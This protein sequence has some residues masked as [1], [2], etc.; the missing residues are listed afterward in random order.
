MALIFTPSAAGRPALGRRSASTRQ[1]PVEPDGYLPACASATH[2]L[3]KLVLAAPESFFS[4]A[5]ASHA[6][7]ASLSH[8]FMKL[9]LAAPASFFSTAIAAQLP[10]G[11]AAAIGALDAMAGASLC[12]AA[13]AE[14]ESASTTAA[15]SEIHC[16]M[17]FSGLGFEATP[18][19]GSRAG[20]DHTT[21]A[22][23]KAH[24]PQR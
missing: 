18:R 8:F 17:N 19:R 13:N 23:S 2:F 6:A 5:L 16:F 11:A 12:E 7:V 14:V 24:A 21:F 9:V 1:R 10:A 4:P 15:D 20:L 3:V 22:R